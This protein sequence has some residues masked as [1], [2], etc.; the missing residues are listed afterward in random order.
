MKNVSSGLAAKKEADDFQSFEREKG[1][2]RDKSDVPQPK[3][4]K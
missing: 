2:Q 1:K 4:K 3:K